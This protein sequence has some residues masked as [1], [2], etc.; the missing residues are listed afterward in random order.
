[1]KEVS[2][3][4]IG[5]SETRRRGEGIPFVMVLFNKQMGW[6]IPDYSSLKMIVKYLV[7]I[8]GEEKVYR[9]L[10]VKREGI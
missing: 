6:W 5:N 4:I 1:M 10:G 2:D 9:M 8:E 3:I 7:S